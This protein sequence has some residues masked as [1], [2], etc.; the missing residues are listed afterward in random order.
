MA[1]SGQR[2]ILIGATLVLAAASSPAYALFNLNDGRT[3]IFVTS[4][5]TAAYDSNLYANSGGRGDMV[6]TW[7]LSSELTRNAGLIGVN[8]SVGVNASRFGKYTGENFNNPRIRAELTKGSGRMTGSFSIAR[9][10][11]GGARHT[12]AEFDVTMKF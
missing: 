7:D 9:G 3:R 1:I 6:Y 12:G 4:S 5:A 8:A 11:T 10:V 2:R